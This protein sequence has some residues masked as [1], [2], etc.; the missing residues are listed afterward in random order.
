MTANRKIH[1]TI[2]KAA[3]LLAVAA[4]AAYTQDGGNPGV[5]ADEKEVGFQESLKAE[6]EALESKLSRLNALKKERE[7]K[8]KSSPREINLAWDPVEGAVKYAVQVKDSGNSLIFDKVVET[9]SVKLA[10]PLGEYRMRVG[11]FNIFEKIGSWSEWSEIKLVLPEAPEAFE[12]RGVIDHGFTVSAG[13]AAIQLLSGIDSLYD[14]STAGWT[15]MAGYRLRTM[16]L[17]SGIPV[18]RNTIIGADI[19]GNVFRGR[20]IKGLEDNKLDILAGSVT[21]SYVT[22]FRFPVNLALRSG[23]GMARTTQVYSTLDGGGGG[24]YSAKELTSTDPCY[25][26]GIG[27]VVSLFNSFYLEGGAEYY[28]VDYLSADLRGIRYLLLT[29]IRI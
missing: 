23:V 20:E 25:R 16:A 11:A 28:V 14:D 12:Q 26:A 6:S 5:P 17:L 13:Y 3:F 24:F 2:F 27:I 18:V 19:S 21:I 9:N 7:V 15:V 22:D 4:G 10:V 29:G 8:A 1:S